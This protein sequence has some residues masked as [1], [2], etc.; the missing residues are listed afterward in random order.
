MAQSAARAGSLRD[1]RRYLA[2]ALL[3]A[4]VGLVLYRYVWVSEE[5]RVRRMVRKGATA[6]EERSVLRCANLVAQ[7]YSD[8]NGFDK[9]TLVDA[10]RRMF[11]RFSK[12]EAE[13]EQLAFDSPPTE[14]QPEE[15]QARVRLRMSVK[16]YED[17]GVA[18]IIDEDP[19][20]EEFVV[21]NL[22]KRNRRWLLQRMEFENVDI[23]DYGAY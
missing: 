2:G 6:V 7:D 21:L 1:P 9:R 8:S 14:V 17:R 19:R 23:L 3:V 5:E 16:L 20:A 11:E 4:L 22:V 15:W 13:V 18:E 12:I 10:A